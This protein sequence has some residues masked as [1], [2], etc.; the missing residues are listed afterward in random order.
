[1]LHLLPNNP[2]VTTNHV[3]VVA[4]PTKTTVTNRRHKRRPVRDVLG[5]V[6]LG[7]LFRNKQG[8]GPQ[9]AHN[10]VMKPAVDGK[11]VSQSLQPYNVRVRRLWERSGSFEPENILSVFQ[12]FHLLNL[13]AQRNVCKPHQNV[14]CPRRTTLSRDD[15][16]AYP[17]NQLR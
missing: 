6:G 3:V 10:R 13:S 7:L 8:P 4:M 11:P 16:P 1:M 12:N 15:P 2:T 5:H 17:A 14:P 9:T